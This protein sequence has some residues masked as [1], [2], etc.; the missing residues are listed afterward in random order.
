MLDELVTE[1]RRSSIVVSFYANAGDWLIVIQG[2]HSREKDA[3]FIEY[4]RE[5]YN[6][7]TVP[8]KLFSKL[9]VTKAHKYFQGKNYTIFFFR[10]SIFPVIDIYNTD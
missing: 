4:M 3:E 1:L 9:L 8:L 7:D 5:K 6:F 10:E 2:R